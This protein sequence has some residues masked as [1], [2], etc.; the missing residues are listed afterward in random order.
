MSPEQPAE[1]SEWRGAL[2]TYVPAVALAFVV[3]WALG[4]HTDWAPRR[5]LVASIVVGIAL[6]IVLER[7]LLRRTGRR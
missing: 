4:S 6:A 7:V 2:L 3:N 1:E 5:A